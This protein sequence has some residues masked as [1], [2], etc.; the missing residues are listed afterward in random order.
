MSENNTNL[1]SAMLNK[2]ATIHQVDNFDPSPFLVEYTDLSTGESH[3]R[4]PVMIQL[5]WFRLRYPEGKITID[6]APAKDCFVATARVYPNYKDASDCYL[7]EATASRGLDTSKPSV[8]PREWAQTA[9]IGI[10]LRNAGFGLQFSAAG[11]DFEKNAV[12]ELGVLAPSSPKEPTTMAEMYI[13]PSPG[14]PAPAAPTP[15]ELYKIALS[16]PCPI[17]KYSGRTL[18]DLITL[19]PKALNWIATKFTGSE[20]IAAAAKLIC[21][22]ALNSLSA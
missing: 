14:S 18:G 5:G 22:H 17:S 3:Q 8:S 11:D 6:V 19:E 16:L 7:A 12:D 4:L 21:E 9:A 10:A 13:V 2:L 20:E 1:K 15:D